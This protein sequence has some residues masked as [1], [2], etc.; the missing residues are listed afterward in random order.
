MPIKKKNKGVAAVDN[1]MK[2]FKFRQNL[3]NYKEF[4]LCLTLVLTKQNHYCIQRQPS[5]AK[6][7]RKNDFN[8]IF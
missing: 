8:E 7:N 4:R 2:M 6:S 5:C 1:S 3:D